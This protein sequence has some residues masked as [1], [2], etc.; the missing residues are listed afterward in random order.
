MIIKGLEKTTLI[1]Y[2]EKVACTIFIFGCNLRC[3]YCHNP[4]LV[5]EDSTPEIDQEEI[6]KFLEERKDFLDGV[7][8]TGGEPTIHKNLPDFLKKIKQLG[9]SIKLDTNGTDPDAVE[10]LIK[11]RLIDYMAMDIK[12]PLEKYEKI[13]KAKVDL[14][15][16]KKSV[17]IIRNSGLDYEFRMTVPPDFFDENDF[18][19]IGKWLKGAKR[20]Y[21]QQFR[22]IKTLDKKFVGKKP[23][24][25]EELERFCN[26]LKPFFEHCEIR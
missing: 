4:E 20:F 21:L 22:G 5:V 7:C 19:K 2:P 16:I 25:K 9:F 15:K 14:E 24:S 10:Q 8:I 23:V 6:L 12:A 26:V 11:D 1:D 18:V 13:V 3:P 17:E